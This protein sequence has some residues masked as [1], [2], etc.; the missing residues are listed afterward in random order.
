ML[1][2]SKEDE[3]DAIFALSRFPSKRVWWGDPDSGLMRVCM[4]GTNKPVTI[5]IVGNIATLWLFSPGE[6]E[7]NS[8][9][10]IGVKPLT[11][12]AMSVGKYILER[13]SHPVASKLFG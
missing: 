7:P 11:Q 9:V 10:S 2:Y 8:K 6:G 1:V 12:H 4:K 3:D 5:W 13:M